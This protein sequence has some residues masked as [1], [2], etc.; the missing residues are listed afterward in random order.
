MADLSVDGLGELSSPAAN[1]EIGIWDVSAGQYLKIQRSTLVGG[2]ITGGGTIATGGFT[3][4]VPATGTAALLTSANLFSAGQI[5][6]P[7]TDVVPLLI[8]PIS[9]STGKQIVIRFNEAERVYY[10]GT[11]TVSRLFFSESDLGSGNAAPYIQIGRNSNA[12]QSPGFVRFIEADGDDNSLYF[13]NSG[14]LRKITDNPPL[15][16][17][18][19]AGDVIGAQTSH[20]DYKTIVGAAVDDSDALAFICAA[21]AQVA[22]FVYKSGAYENQEFSGLVLDGE[23][24]DRYGQDA[25]AE[26]AA[27]KSLNVIN[28]IGDLFLSVRNLASRISMLESA[29]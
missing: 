3:L 9:S 12:N 2:T 21:A 23:T 26:H 19:A 28:A 1:D 22:R 15:F 7:S 14:I 27:G 24:L 11:A 29:R 10:L 8:D 17:T 6:A 13:D 25:D 20:V 5:I 18:F 16:N 4:T